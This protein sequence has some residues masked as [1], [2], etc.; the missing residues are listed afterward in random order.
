ME[1]FMEFEKYK[2]M[3]KELGAINVVK[4]SIEE[5]VFDPRVALKC[6]F[7]CD[8]YGRVHN[9]LFQKSPLNMA[10]YKEIFSHY[11]WGII[12]RTENLEDSQRIA[13]EVEREAFLDGHY[14]ALSLS[15]CVL[16]EKCTRIDQMGECRLPLQSRPSFHGIGID[17][18]KTV[19]ALGLPLKIARTHDDEV[20]YYSAVFVA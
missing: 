1:V 19:N 16:C 15:D 2:K 6:L 8:T 10:Q 13:F 12:I 17:V 3:A 5:I 14:F 9:C 20:N 11:S 4:F 7:G 18:V